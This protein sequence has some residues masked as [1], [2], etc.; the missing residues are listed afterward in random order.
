MSPALAAYREILV[1]EGALLQQFIELLEREQQAL[2]EGAND[3]LPGLADQKSRMSEQLIAYE[4]ERAQLQSR[5][6]IGGD[7][8]QIGAWLSRL[9]ADA[10]AEWEKF[11]GLVARA[12]D[13]NDLNGRLIG[14]RLKN[15]QQAIHALMA[16]ANQ[17]ATY[18]PKGQSLTGN[19]SR[20]LGSA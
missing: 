1:K 3:T 12:K 14:E 8:G 11:L 9:A 20:S 10:A 6:G 18:G 19:V 17:T 2:V 13:L 5:E 4:Q 7:K 16:A 15:N